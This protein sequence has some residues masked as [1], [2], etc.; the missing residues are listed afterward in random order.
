LLQI[1]AAIAFLNVSH[2]AGRNI[3][4]LNGFYLGC[5]IIAF[6]ALFSSFYS[7]RH[8][9][10]LRNWEMIFPIPMMIWGLMWWFGA[11]FFEIDKHVA[12]SYQKQATLLFI[13][14]SSL[15][16]GELSHILQWK[17]ISYPQWL[18]LP[19]MTIYAL[20]NAADHPSSHPFVRIGS[21]AWIAAFIAQYRFLWQHRENRNAQLTM[22]HL[23]S[24]WLM[25]FLLTGES[26]WA[27][28]ELVHGAGTW[29]F[30]AWGLCSAAFG[31]I[32]L[33]KGRDIRWPVAPNL[34]DYLDKGV[35][36]IWFWL[37]LWGLRACFKEGDPWPLPYLPLLNP[38]DIA[39][40]FALIVMIRWIW[41]LQKN[42]FFV[43]GTVLVIFIHL[44][45]VIART[46]HFW[47]DVPFS[48][49]AMLDSTVFQASV[50][51]LWTLI[52]FGVMVWAARKSKREVWIV[53]AWILGIV[54]VKLFIKDLDGTGTIGRIVSFLAVGIIMLIIGYLSPLPPKRI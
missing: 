25:I 22:W 31:V 32:L 52:A 19:C 18:L 5:L 26:A 34:S 1:G 45:M 41:Q 35:M 44:T 21:L 14:L 54:V 47:G 10:K 50:S 7:D 15:C 16:M 11:G 12:Y 27:I 38:L 13:S 24:L 9:D 51:I 2:I 17:A 43:Y 49:P 36:A 39:Q 4:I 20:G 30:I 29:T 28:N 46:V 37:L 3:P 8:K 48:Q 23:A 40:I 42:R 33:A 6:A 53:G